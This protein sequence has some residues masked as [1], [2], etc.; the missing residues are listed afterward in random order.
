M[1]NMKRQ[2]TPTDI[3]CDKCGQANFVIKFG[4]NGKFL[5]C[6]RYPECKEHARFFR[7]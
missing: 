5:A 7:G 3:P 6:P 4:R 1:K 2:E